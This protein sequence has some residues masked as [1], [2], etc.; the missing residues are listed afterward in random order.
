V[1]IYNTDTSDGDADGSS[2]DGIWMIDS[3]GNACAS[4]GAWSGEQFYVYWD[5]TCN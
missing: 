4:P 5:A 3:N 1:L 2:H